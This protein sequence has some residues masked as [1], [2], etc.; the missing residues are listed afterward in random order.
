MLRLYSVFL[1][2]RADGCNTELH[3]VVFVIGESIQQVYPT[4]VNKWFG[5]KKML[6]ID[7]YIELTHADSHDIVLSNQS[8]NEN[9]KLFYV[10]FGS[11]KNGYFGEIHESGFY[12]GTSKNEVLMRAKNELCV[13]GVE[14]HC[15]DNVVVD[16]VIEVSY[17]DHYYLHFVPSERKDVNIIS[18]YQPLDLSGILHEASLL[19]V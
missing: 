12:V 5:N 1:G 14:P 7:S 19:A 13:R 10:N 2:G 11:Y 9:K 8:N 4:L 6:H 18:H 3:D 17:I 16:D 15:D